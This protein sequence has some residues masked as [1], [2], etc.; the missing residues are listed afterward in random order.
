MGTVRYLTVAPGRLGAKVKQELQGHS[1]REG[2]NFVI[3]EYIYY[4]LRER[5]WNPTVRSSVTEVV[6]E[7]G[8]RETKFD[9][10]YF[11]VCCPIRE[12]A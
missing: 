11:R 3:S 6:P 1:S 4:V 7:W 10:D 12:R 8:Q 2:T 9:A 5:G